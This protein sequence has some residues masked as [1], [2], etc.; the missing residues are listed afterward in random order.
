MGLA[1]EIDRR[2][3]TPPQEHLSSSQTGKAMILN[4][5]AFVCAPLYLFGEFFSG[6]ATEHLLRE[7]IKPEHLNDDRL[8]RVLDKLFEADLSESSSGSPARPPSALAFPQRERSPRCHL[9]SSARSLRRRR[10]GAPR[11]PLWH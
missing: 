8:G 9:F 4:G 3:G 7:G 10:T 5:L 2:V 11:D 6:K 1:E